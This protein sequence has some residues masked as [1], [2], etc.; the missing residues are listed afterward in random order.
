[1][2]HPTILFSPPPKIMLVLKILSESRDT[3]PMVLTVSHSTLKMFML[4]TVVNPEVVHTKIDR[5]CE[6]Q[7]V[8][9]NVMIV[10]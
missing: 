4:G 10:L 7:P 5:M 8:G 1:M 9:R 3:S 6:E 2:G